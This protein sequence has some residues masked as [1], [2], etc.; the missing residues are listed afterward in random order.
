MAL[1]R[2]ILALTRPARLP[3]VWSSCLAGWWLGGDRDWELLP[4]LLA[5]ASF[6]FFGGAF[7]NDAF[8]ADYDREHRPHRPIPAGEVAVQT[9][10]RWGLAWLILGA[11]LLL[12]LGKLS[13]TLGLILVLLIVFYTALHRQTSVAPVLKG[14]CRCFLYLLGASI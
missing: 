1:V 8:D 13:G 4:L 2:T 9:V 14:L 12:W 5:G 6:L 3:T 11:L 7:L 10:W